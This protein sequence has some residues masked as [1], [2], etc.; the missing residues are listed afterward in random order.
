MPL[1]VASGG[2]ITRTTHSS[3]STNSAQRSHT[4]P[5]HHNYR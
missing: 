3:N 5:E 4:L 2:H 1:D